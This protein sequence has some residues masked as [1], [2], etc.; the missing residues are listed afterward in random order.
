MQKN[1]SSVLYFQL[2]G[3]QNAQSLK[4]PLFCFFLIIYIIILLG[5]FL[6]M[7]L[8]LLS[9]K[10]RSPMYFFLSHLSLCD[11]F[12]TTNIIPNMLHI[13]LLEVVPMPVAECL[14]QFYLFGCSTSTES[15]LLTVM[16]YDRYLAICYP[17]H[18]LSIMGAHLRLH[19]VAWS[20]LLGFC[21]TLIPG[22]L[23]ST[24]EFCGPNT[25]DHFFCD[26]APFLKLSCSDVYMV[27]TE[28]IVC[29]I[30]IILFPF[31]FI[32]M[33]YVNIFLT[34][35]KIPSKAGRQKAF[36][37]CSSHLIVVCTYY[38]TLIIVYMVPTKGHF[39]GINKVL[40][41][42]YIIVTPFFNPI[43]YSLRNKELQVAMRKIVCNM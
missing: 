24:L 3:F 19:L 34:I 17:L 9:Q 16:S 31:F 26:L 39:T 7:V 2:L 43:I 41:L 6:I 30:P 27:E 12:C 22:L 35:L 10:L 11:V 42:L 32:M 13:L 29:S 28:I 4:I 18:Y 5:N 33:T 14:L 37:T 40:S 23:V 21:L 1:Q 36:S 38:G 8:V 15:L 20:W 25:I